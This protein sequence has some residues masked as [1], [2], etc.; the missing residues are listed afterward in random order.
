[1]P[2]RSGTAAALLAVV[3]GCG[4]TKSIKT[5]KLENMNTLANRETYDILK[6]VE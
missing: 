2:D 6:M 3:S 1:L 4:K 5:T